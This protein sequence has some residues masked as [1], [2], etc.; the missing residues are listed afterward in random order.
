MTTS[1]PCC[2]GSGVPDPL[3]PGLIRW[4]DAH[5]RSGERA[6]LLAVVERVVAA[7]PKGAK[8]SQAY[9]SMNVFFA[10]NRRRHVYRAL[11]SAF[12]TE[13][14]L[15]VLTG[16]V[17][18]LPLVRRV[19]TRAAS[20]LFRL[21]HRYLVMAAVRGRNVE[22]IFID[23]A[24]AT[25]LLTCPLIK[26]RCPLRSST[27][28]EEQD[29]R[30]RSLVLLK[31]CGEATL[32]L[33]PKDGY[34]YGSRHPS[35]GE[36]LAATPFFGDSSP[37]SFQAFFGEDPVRLDLTDAGRYEGRA[38]G[39]PTLGEPCSA[40]VGSAQV[41]SPRRMPTCVSPGQTP[42]CSSIHDIEPVALV[43]PELLATAKV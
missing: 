33:R 28:T 15:M 30:Q 24:L 38:E 4:F 16:N 27:S 39:H 21:H 37:P 36:Q 25:P 11:L 14:T 1:L 7:R 43:V 17:E 26:T 34:R 20:A 8:M 35:L 19:R 9:R 3:T 40:R 13:I 42:H 29:G 23:R 41:P 31:E 10:W 22:G 5:I 2:V 18:P 32:Y 12:E 6:G